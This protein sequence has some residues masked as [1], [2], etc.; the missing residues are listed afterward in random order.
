MG[1][2]QTLVQIPFPIWRDACGGETAR[3]PEGQSRQTCERWPTEVAG[4]CIRGLDQMMNAICTR[5]VRDVSS[6]THHCMH[7]LTSPLRHGTAGDQARCIHVASHII[8]FTERSIY[9]GTLT[10]A[11]PETKDRVV[12]LIRGDPA[13]HQHLVC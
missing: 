12:V 6:V 13:Y 9:R 1:P 11:I 7:A 8:S 2:D 3:L 4:I 5:A 10:W